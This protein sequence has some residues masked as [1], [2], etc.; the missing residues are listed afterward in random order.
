MLESLYGTIVH[1]ATS[2]LLSSMEMIEAR[3]S[4]IR[5]KLITCLQELTRGKQGEGRL[6][7]KCKRT[8]PANKSSMKILSKMKN[9]NSL[10]KNKVSTGWW[11]NWY[12]NLTYIV[13]YNTN[14]RW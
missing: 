7:K 5:H 2:H 14:T 9:L 3:T 8:Y 6:V 10:A 1:I 12:G 4:F 11:R 13:S